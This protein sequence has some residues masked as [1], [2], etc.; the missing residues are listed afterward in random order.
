MPLGDVHFWV[1]FYTFVITPL[2][3][4]FY[5]AATCT[6]NQTFCPIFMVV[7]FQKYAILQL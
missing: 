2:G 4:R 5:Y 6:E 1:V 7:L 3:Y